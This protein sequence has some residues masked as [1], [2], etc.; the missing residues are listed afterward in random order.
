[1]KISIEFPD[2][3]SK[4]IYKALEDSGV[5]YETQV[6]NQ[7]QGERNN[8]VSKQ[9]S[10]DYQ[11][12]AQL[13][14]SHNSDRFNEYVKYYEE[15]ILNLVEELNDDFKSYLNEIG[16]ILTSQKM[17][18]RDG[19]SE[20]SHRL[21]GF[22]LEFKNL[23]DTLKVEKYEKL[24]KGIEELIQKHEEFRT[25]QLYF[26][27]RTLEKNDLDRIIDYTNK[28]YYALLNILMNLRKLL[29]DKLLKVKSGYEYGVSIRNMVN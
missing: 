10:E 6:L 19:F 5:R 24:E 2:N 20:Y 4:H 17:F 22:N 18:I 23:I 7:E 26:I 21:D 1:M 27:E 16:R 9:V 14:L 13:G 12:G 15:Q 25:D 29:E 3:M 11:I 28:S 8:E